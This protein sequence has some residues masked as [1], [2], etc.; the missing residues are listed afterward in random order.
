MDTSTL[1]DLLVGRLMPEKCYEELFVR[2]NLHAPCLKFVLNK[3][4]GIWIILDAFL[5]NPVGC[6]SSFLVVC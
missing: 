6:G 1:K 2:F 3:I 4:V 5:V